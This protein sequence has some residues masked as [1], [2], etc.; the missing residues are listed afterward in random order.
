VAP[1]TLTRIDPNGHREVE[2]TDCYIAPVGQERFSA[3]D[4]GC[5]LFTRSE[6]RAEHAAPSA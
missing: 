5:V 3:I 6:G 2:I 1:E 4:F